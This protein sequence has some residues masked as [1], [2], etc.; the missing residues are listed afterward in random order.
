MI[1]TI[2]VSMMERGIV[3][4]AILFILYVIVKLF[5]KHLIKT[6]TKKDQNHE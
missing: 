4:L 2:D 3:I 6:Q 5:E 1:A